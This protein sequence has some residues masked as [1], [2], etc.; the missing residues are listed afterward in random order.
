[1]SIYL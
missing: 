1:M